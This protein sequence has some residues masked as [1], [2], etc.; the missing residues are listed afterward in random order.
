MPEGVHKY[1]SQQLAQ[2]GHLIYASVNSLSFFCFLESLL[3]FLE[4]PG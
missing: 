1:L 2:F 3:R 4:Y